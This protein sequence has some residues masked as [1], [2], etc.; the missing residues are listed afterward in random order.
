MGIIANAL[1]KELVKVGALPKGFK[2]K[3]KGKS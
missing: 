1:A 2:V 3:K